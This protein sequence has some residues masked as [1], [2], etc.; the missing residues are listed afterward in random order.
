MITRRIQPIKLDYLMMNPFLPLRKE[1]IVGGTESLILFHE[2]LF[3]KCS[4]LTGIPAI[5]L[6]NWKIIE[7]INVSECFVRSEFVW[8]EQYLFNFYRLLEYLV[9]SNHQKNVVLRSR[10]N[11]HSHI[12]KTIAVVC[13]FV[14]LDQLE[15]IKND[16]P[17]FSNIAF[18]SAN[19][20]NKVLVDTLV[21]WLKYLVG[22]INDKAKVLGHF[23][24]AYNKKSLRQNSACEWNDDC[25][26]YTAV[27]YSDE[28]IRSFISYVVSH[29]DFS[30]DEQISFV[31]SAYDYYS[32]SKITRHDLF[33]KS[34]TCLI[35][36]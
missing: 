9:D 22:S 26:T 29:L 13:R 12:N 27:E 24:R 7:R 8:H 36:K 21:E 23:L 6:F 3:V 5:D 35:L 10:D 17:N 16:Y 2:G 31:S 15:L 33:N 32:F 4:S 25:P 19:F 30:D 18:S 28:E 20:D 1:F 14:D 11:A 34:N